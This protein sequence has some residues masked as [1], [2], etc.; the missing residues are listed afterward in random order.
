M[1]ER[2][3]WK[4]RVVE[5]HRLG[6]AAKKTNLQ[7]APER[8]AVWLRLEIPAHFEAPAGLVTMPYTEVSHREEGPVRGLFSPCTELNSIF[9]LA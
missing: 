6:L 1:G 8:K 9:Q 3:A 7:F 4:N 5:D 2:V